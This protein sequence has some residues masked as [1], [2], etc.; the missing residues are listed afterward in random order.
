MIAGKDS[1]AQFL[2]HALKEKCHSGEDIETAE[3]LLFLPL[4]HSLAFHWKHPLGRAGD[5]L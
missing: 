1:G 5:G 2:F 3:T 4:L